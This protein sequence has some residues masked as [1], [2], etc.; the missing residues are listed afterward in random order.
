LSRWGSILVS[1]FA[2]KFNL[3]RYIKVVHLT[4]SQRNTDLV[5]RVGR[6]SVTQKALEVGLAVCVRYV[7]SC[8]C[9]RYVASSSSCT[10]VAC[11]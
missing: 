1:K 3:H 8:N 5:E 11:S 7:S 2:F 9:V 10:A 6:T 4:F